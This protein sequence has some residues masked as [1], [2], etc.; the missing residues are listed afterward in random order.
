MP[1][2]AYTSFLPYERV[3]KQ[4]Y[5]CTCQCPLGLIPHFYHMNAYPSNYIVVRVNALSGLYLISTNVYDYIAVTH[6][7]EGVN[8]LSGLYLISTKKELDNMSTIDECQCPLG[9]IPHFYRDNNDEY[10]PAGPCVNALSG[11]YL[12]STVPLQKPRFYAVSR[13]CFCRY[14]SEYS[15]NSRFS[16][17]LTFWTYLMRCTYP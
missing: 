1:S 5:R 15:D 17:M 12:I 16:C 8:A 10:D 2:R 6:Y 13:A 4:L 9:L 14:L 11:L 7:I 3:S